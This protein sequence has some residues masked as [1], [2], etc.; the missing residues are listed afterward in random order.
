MKRSKNTCVF[1]LFSPFDFLILI[2]V[3]FTAF[4]PFFFNS[5]GEKNDNFTVFYGE[6][7]IEIPFDGDTILIINFVK[8]HIKDGSAKIMESNC[9]NQICVAQIP[10]N[11]NGQIVCVPNKII[12]S[13]NIK[14]KI[15]PK[16]DVY[17]Y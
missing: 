17:A 9:P 5:F 7:K 2:F 15:Q 3:V 13:R 8:I 4:F 6:R 12:V 11:Q 1:Q 14:S 10:L 16:V